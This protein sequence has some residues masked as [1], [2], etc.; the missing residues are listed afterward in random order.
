MF[1]EESQTNNIKTILLAEPTKKP[2]SSKKDRNH[3][4]PKHEKSK[5]IIT[6]TKLW[7]FSPQELSHEY[8][9]EVLV[10][11]MPENIDNKSPERESYTHIIK[12]IHGEI[13]KK[14]YG[15]KCQDLKKELFSPCEFV[16]IEN[17]IKKLKDCNL[18]CYYCKEPIYILY[19]FVREP[20][21]W[22]LERI[23]NAEGHTNTNT[24]IACLKC[25]LSRRCIFH[26]RYLFTK[27]ISNIVKQNIY[28]TP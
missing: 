25:N 21:Q 18:T 14:I 24:E 13:Q 12:F 22:T 16:K 11:I 15:Y 9:K 7:N 6:T 23:N 5:R 26:E 17:I 28:N 3:P 2:R 27:Q 19:E 20:M 1:S 8:Q 4:P 10:R